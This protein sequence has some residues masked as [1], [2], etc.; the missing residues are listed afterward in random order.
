MVPDTGDDGIE[1]LAVEH[2]TLTADVAFARELRTLGDGT[3]R[4]SRQGR[5]LAAGRGKRRHRAGRPRGPQRE[6][7]N[8]QHGADECGKGEAQRRSPNW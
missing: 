4:E 1:A 3:L 8:G 5:H 6:A 2:R 7:E